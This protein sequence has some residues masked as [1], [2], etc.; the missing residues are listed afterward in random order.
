MLRVTQLLN[1]LFITLAKTSIDQKSS[2]MSYTHKG[3]ALINGMVDPG[4]IITDEG[5]L[6]V[7]AE[8]DGTQIGGYVKGDFEWWYFDIY[9]QAAGFFLKIVLHIGTNPVRTKVISQLAVSVST[10]EGNSSLSFPFNIS[11]LSSNNWQCNLSVGDKIRIWTVLDHPPGYFIKIDIP[12]FK[13]DFR[14]K[15]ELEGWKPFGKNI[16]YQRGNKRVD[17]SW[18]IPMP[19]ARVEGN[20]NFEKNKYTLS[21][22]KGYHDHNYI[23]I[24]RKDPLYLD[25]Q[26]IKWYWGKCFAGNFTVIFMDIWCRV[27]RTLS[28]MVAENDRIIHSSNNQIEC[29]VL[30][31]GF[32]TLL[33]TGYPS[34]IIIKS[35]DKEFPFR[36]EFESEKILDHRDLLEGVNPVIRFLIRRLVAKPAYH[37]ILAKVRLEIGNQILKGSGNFESMVFR[38]N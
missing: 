11:E 6:T 12:G 19:K 21:E 16:P 8:D 26:V 3:K 24:D 32:D 28:L 36:A 38:G 29:S 4:Q 18:V 25:D 13:C 22:G 34:S 33:K 9:D 30:S 7:T 1:I 2:L 27:N 14:F 5:E 20:F 37:G 10:P 17:L 31:S 35:I 15:G 23:K